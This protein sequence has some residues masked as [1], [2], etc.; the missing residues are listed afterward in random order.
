MASPK[1]DFDFDK[2]LGFDV[3]E[4]VPTKKI[5]LLGKD[6]TIMCDLNS[7]AMARIASGEASGVATFITNLVVPDE[8]EE[9]TAALEGAKNMTGERLGL[10]LQHL[11]EV[12]GERPTEQPSRSPRTAKNQTSS[13]RSVGN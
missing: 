12:A 7:F 6:W 10:L 4:S 9:F 5:R 3:D 2:A 11:V 8:R 1:V 13:L